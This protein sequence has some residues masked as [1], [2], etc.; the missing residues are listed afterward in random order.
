M[1]QHSTAHAPKR[2]DVPDPTVGASPSK[3]ARREVSSAHKDKKREKR[4]KEKE[5]KEKGKGKKADGEFRA[6]KASVV[7]ALSPAFASKPHDG[8]EEMLDSMVM[9]YIPTLR[10]VVLAHSNMHFLE[11]VGRIKGDCPFAICNV[12]FEA[13]TWSPEMG[14]KLVIDAYHISLLVHRTFNVSI[15]RHHIPTDQW[16]FEYG[17]AENDPEFGAIAAEKD[18]VADITEDN[19][20]GGGAEE[21]EGGA[22]QNVDRGGRW[23]HKVTGDQL[24]GED[25]RLE[26]TSHT[27]SHHAGARSPSP[28]A[29]IE[30][31]EAAEGDDD[32]EVDPFVQLGRLGDEA[33]RKAREEREAQEKEREREKEA[34][35]KRKRKEKEK[36]GEGEGNDA[37][38]KKKKS[39]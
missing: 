9:R 14:M 7:L 36:R 37:A 21:G 25:G 6:V 15:P 38:K 10:G 22:S 20:A 16:E 4:E 26:F 8:A 3:K 35:K 1:P 5:K 2:K 17:P 24:G 13:T 27:Q 39:A 31:G 19:A 29:E 34:R 30:D 23:I 33:E 18:A 11:S 32:I 28:P 12:G